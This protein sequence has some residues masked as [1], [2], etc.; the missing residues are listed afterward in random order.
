MA[1]QTITAP[2][3]VLIADDNP[4]ILKQIK[5]TLEQEH[6][7]VVTVSDGREAQELLDRD[8][9]FIAAIVD[10]KIPSI[11]GPELVRHMRAEERLRKIPVMM[12]NVEEDDPR[13]LINSMDAG[14]MV[15]LPK[16]FDLNQM[17]KMLRF[18]IPQKKS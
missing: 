18:L 5:R 3:R 12:I 4:E 14:A 1:T 6:M 8:A 10:I 17:K 7:K 13:V 11:T 9:D 16:P 15:S 2:N